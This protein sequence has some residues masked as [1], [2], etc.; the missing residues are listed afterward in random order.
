M[1]SILRS[2]FVAFRAAEPLLRAEPSRD[3]QRRMQMRDSAAAGTCGAPRRSGRNPGGARRISGGGAKSGSRVVSSP[4][5]ARCVSSLGP[6]QDGGPVSGRAHTETRCDGEGQVSGW[7]GDAAPR[8]GGPRP[9]F[10]CP[11]GWLRSGGCGPQLSRRGSAL[12][13]PSRSHWLSCGPAGPLCHAIGGGGRHSGLG[14]GSGPHLGPC[15][16]RC[17]GGAGVLS[18]PSP[19]GLFGTPGAFPCLTEPSDLPSACP[20]RLTQRCSL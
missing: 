7:H 1:S 17:H 16:W 10:E 12:L 3:V 5:L 13:P 14:W 2:V 11:F 20:R 9:L 6:R 15:A 4:G 18:G 8:A 19:F